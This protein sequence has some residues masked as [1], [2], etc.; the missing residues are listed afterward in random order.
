MLIIPKLR[1]PNNEPP[2]ELVRK[3]MMVEAVPIHRL[4]CLNWPA[5]YPYCPQV[6]FQVAYGRDEIY[7]RFFVQ[8]QSVKAQYTQSNEA[9]W[10]DSCVEFFL[11][12]DSDQTYYNLET[13]CIGT[14]LFGYS[15]G[16]HP[17]IHADP[18]VISKIRKTSSLGN[19]PFAEINQET[20]WEI[21]MAIPL[22]CFFAHQLRGPLNGK[23]MTANFYKCGDELTVPHFVSWTSI[24]TPEPSFHQPGY[25][26]EIYFE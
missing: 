8:E 25:F 4:E 12:I 6:A 7:L 15:D 5:S 22:E 18:Q 23:K 14:Q 2:I 19:L 24:P 9:V 17:R 16:T 3:M 10:T 11:S 13:N 1:F 21:C 20:Y 26:G